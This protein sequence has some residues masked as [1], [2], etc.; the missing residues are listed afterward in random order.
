MLLGSRFTPPANWRVSVPVEGGPGTMAI[1][2]AFETSAR[3]G[4]TWLVV[5]G[6][7]DAYTSPRLRE[8]LGELMDQGRFNLVVD[9]ESVEFMDSTG[10]GVLV[11]SLKRAKEH[12][13]NIA[14]VCSRPQIVRVLSITGLDRIFEVRPGEAPGASTGSEE[15]PG[16]TAPVGRTPDGDGADRARDADERK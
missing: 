14:L 11:S 16:T 10:L 5:R 8:R 4:Q 1:E 2:L 13:G 9:L 3:D 6:E 7:I 15:P 12:D